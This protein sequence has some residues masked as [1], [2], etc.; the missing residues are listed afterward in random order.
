LND[1][2]VFNQKSKNKR[3]LNIKNNKDIIQNIKKNK[4]SIS[5]KNK[6]NLTKKKSF[7]TIRDTVIN[8][9][10][11]HGKIIILPTLN[12]SRDNK[13]D[14]DKE[15]DINKKSKSLQGLQ[16]SS[17][18]TKKL[19]NY[20]I[21]KIKREKLSASSLTNYKLGDLSSKTYNINVNNTNN[22]IS[23]EI[24][25]FNNN[26][27]KDYILYNYNTN[28]KKHKKDKSTLF[29]LFEDQ[30][31][32]GNYF[33]PHQNSQEKNHSK[34]NR[35]KIE[36]YYRNNMNINYGNN[37]KINK[38]NL[39]NKKSKKN[40][41]IMNSYINNN[42]IIDITG[43]FHN[44]QK[45]SNITNKTINTI[46]NNNFKNNNSNSSNNIIN[47]YDK[48][49]YKHKRDNNCNYNYKSTNKKMLNLTH[50]AENNIQKVMNNIIK[51]F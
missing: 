11:G 29:K 50:R 42:M 16:K 31:N 45:T 21:K 20:L 7:F 12:K 10:T 4:K 41:L 39:I 14:K 17:N 9:D 49:N 40:H 37:H 51:K 6:I 46:T 13:K 44:K 36:E 24:L 26:N 1:L 35:V 30:K 25:S 47:A 33:I 3:N 2:K 23:K 5:K 38:I 18:N 15:N 48:N 8:F 28:N 43:N 19:T 27:N 34:F 22:N 32:S